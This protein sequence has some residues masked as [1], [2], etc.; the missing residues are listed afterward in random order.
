MKKEKIAISLDNSLLP[1]VD[2]Y[3][4]NVTI[5]S[6]SQAIEFLLKKAIKERPVDTA[7]LLI[8]K[9]DQKYLFKEFEGFSLVQ[10]NFNF[11]IKHKFKKLYII[12][13]RT[14]EI[15]DLI[16]ELPKVIDI[17]LIEEK[18]VNGTAS[19]LLLLK[20]K[21][22]SN[23]ILMN[24]DTFNDFAL[25]NM[26]KEHLNNNKVVTIGLISSDSPSKKGSVILDGNLI[27]D[28][29]EKEKTKSYVVSAGVYVIN[30]KIFSYYSKE[31]KSLEKDIF[32][33]LAKEK[34]LQGFFT[35]GKFVHMPE[36]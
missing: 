16:K 25:D 3:V 7:V 13:E 19:A 9:N 29:K 27:I 21:L 2:A 28:F 35:W 24:G 20:D 22:K 23:F 10:H 26:I 5:R 4:D 34:Q 30:P 15:E 14:E 17:E 6:R 33:K 8:R 12:T 11:M 31:S 36:F 1:I 32:P 18:N